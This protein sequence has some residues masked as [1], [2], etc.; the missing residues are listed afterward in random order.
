MWKPQ[1]GAIDPSVTLHPA[2]SPN[3]A[4]AKRSTGP[5]ATTVALPGDLGLGG[6]WCGLLLARAL[7]HN[8]LCDFGSG[9]HRRCYRNRLVVLELSHLGLLV[10]VRLLLIGVRLLRSSLEWRCLHA[11]RGGERLLR[12]DEVLLL[13]GVRLGLGLERRDEILLVGVRLG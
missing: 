5:I 7:L 10:G 13:I 3:Q 9:L 12:G 6:E 4:R 1:E 11:G 2:R 8:R